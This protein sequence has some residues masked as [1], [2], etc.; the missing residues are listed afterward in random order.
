MARLVIDMTE[1]QKKAIVDFATQ[2][3]MKIKEAV[4]DV[5]QKT[6]KDLREKEVKN[7]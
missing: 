6:I 3:K 4:F 1:A 7:N 2:K 5:L